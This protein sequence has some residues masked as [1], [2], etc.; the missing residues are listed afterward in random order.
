MEPRALW[1]V[2]VTLGSTLPT[3][4]GLPCWPLHPCLGQLMK[5]PASQ[6]SL[7]SRDLTALKVQQRSR[8]VEIARLVLAPWASILGLGSLAELW[9]PFV[10]P[11][12][13]RQIR[14]PH[15]MCH[16]WL[17]GQDAAVGPAVDWGGLC[18]HRAGGG[19]CA[20]T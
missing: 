10:C 6:E 14:D 1:S 2:S 16:P 4:D 9:G 15:P 7:R 5:V 12:P 11:S 20:D 13:D 18:S 8:H 19:G 3:L 17:W